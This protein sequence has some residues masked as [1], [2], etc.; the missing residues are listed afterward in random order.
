MNFRGASEG[1]RDPHITVTESTFQ[2]ARSG[3]VANTRDL[4][5]VLKA[6]A[7]ADHRVTGN[8]LLKQ[9]RDL[10]KLACQS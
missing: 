8:S 7:Y 2:I 1:G 5:L 6:E 4:R 10:M 3:K 9:L